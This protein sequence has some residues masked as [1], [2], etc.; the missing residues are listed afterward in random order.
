MLCPSFGGRY[1]SASSIMVSCNV[2]VEHNQE[3]TTVDREE[4]CV[5]GKQQ[6]SVHYTAIPFKLRS[7]RA[8]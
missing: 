6:Q 1:T 3:W 4:I 8:V 5:S 2:G 7:I